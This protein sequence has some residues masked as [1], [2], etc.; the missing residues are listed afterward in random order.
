M[1]KNNFLNSAYNTL[2]ELSE[3]NGNQLKKVTDY[4]DEL[5]YAGAMDFKDGASDTMEA[6]CLRFLI[7]PCSTQFTYIMPSL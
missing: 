7:T 2:S 3:R 4:C 1:G 6:I 5:T